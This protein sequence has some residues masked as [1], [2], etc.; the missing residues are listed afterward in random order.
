MIGDDP[1]M[2]DR[3]KYVG[4]PNYLTEYVGSESLD[5]IID[6]IDPSHFLDVSRFQEANISRAICAI[7]G[8]QNAP[9]NFGILIHL[10]R[11]TRDGCEM[12]S[13]FWLG[14]LET[15]RL[16]AKRILDKIVSTKFAA[17]KAVSLELGRDMVVHCAMEMNHLA[18]FLP[19]LYTD[20]HSAT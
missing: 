15:Q 5:L 11:E 8:Y 12:R 10:I 2:S 3:E 20:Y 6:L 1:K 4:N 17:K 18:S 19:D 16:P 9:L 7:V 14:N 13:R